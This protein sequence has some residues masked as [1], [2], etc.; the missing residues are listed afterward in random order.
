MIIIIII[1]IITKTETF[2]F[3]LTSLKLATSLLLSIYNFF[4]KLNNNS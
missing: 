3:L 1:I 2:D 4:L